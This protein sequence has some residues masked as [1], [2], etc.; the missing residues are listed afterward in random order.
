MTKPVFW[1]WVAG[2]QASC[3]YEKLC[4]WS[5]GSRR[6]SKF[7]DAYLISYPPNA[8]LPRHKDE[9]KAGA[10]YRLNVELRGT[11]EFH[12]ERPLFKLWRIVLFR[13][14]QQEH[15]MDNGPTKRLVLSFG[16]VF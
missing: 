13:P 2:R 15:G 8:Q 1:R 14:D 3:N 7:M 16:F 12:C 5:F 6:F 10:H 4:L 11:G 9:V